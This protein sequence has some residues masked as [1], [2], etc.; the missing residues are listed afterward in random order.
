GNNAAS[1]RG[2]P[3]AGLQ[4]RTVGRLPRR[5]PE[6]RRNRPGGA[7]AAPV[8]P[9]AP[10]VA[11]PAGRA[12]PRR[13]LHRRDLAPRAAELPQ[14]RAARQL[15]AA[16]ARRRPAGLHPVP[17]ADDR[18]RLLPGEPSGLASAAEGTGEPD[19]AATAAVLRVE[20]GPV[21]GWA[22]QAPV[23]KPRAF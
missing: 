6:R 15:P 9:A 11:Q 13:T 5:R 4:P 18:L 1:A 16:S 14:P 23:V 19:A 20:R 21:A 3:H 22:E 17:F 12:R 2:L 8:R 7:G 10:P